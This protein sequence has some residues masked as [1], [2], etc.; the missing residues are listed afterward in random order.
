MEARRDDKMLRQITDKF[1]EI[2][3]SRGLTQGAVYEDTGVHVAKYETSSYTLSIT[4]IA[5]LC[6]YFDI[7]LK[8]F[9]DGITLSEDMNQWK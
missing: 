3:K 1:R 4:T 2:R 6:S 8:D 7:S 5:I 9:F